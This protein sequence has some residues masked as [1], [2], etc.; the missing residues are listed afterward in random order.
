MVK[1]GLIKLPQVS[2][3]RLA[4]HLILAVILYNLLFWQLMKNRLEILLLPNDINL[5]VIKNIC[6]VIIMVL[7]GQIFLGALVAGLD[8][9]LVYNSF[10]LMG[11]SFVP[12][13]FSLSESSIIDLLSEPAALQ[14]MHRM[15]A[16]LLLLGVLCLFFYLRST[17]IRRLRQ[18][19]IVL[20]SLVLLQGFLGIMTI[21]Y[22]VPLLIA[23]L[24]Q[25]GA[26]FLLS[27]LI[28]CY[29]LVSRKSII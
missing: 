25:I 6:F 13:E 2:H 22:H 7:Y 11:N 21:L 17:Q 16:Y 10:P 18:L 23:L 5:S 4:M 24:H 15:G 14:F 27:C 1:S 26:V 29:F 28:W 9:G 19:S 3:Y 12:P 20:L 8:A